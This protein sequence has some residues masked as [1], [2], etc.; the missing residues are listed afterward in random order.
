ML[1]L[2]GTEIIWTKKITRYSPLFYPGKGF[3]MKIAESERVFISV[4]CN[5][6]LRACLIIYPRLIRP[7]F[8]MRN[9]PILRRRQGGAEKEH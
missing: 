4:F 2:T 7:A 6:M 1:S 9:W 5:R 8:S 3:E